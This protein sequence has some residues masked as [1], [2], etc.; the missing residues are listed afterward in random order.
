MLAVFQRRYL[1]TM[2]YALN[3][4]CQQLRSE[5]EYLTGGDVRI[6]CCCS[7]KVWDIRGGL[8]KVQDRIDQYECHNGQNQRWRLMCINVSMRLFEIQSPFCGL[9]AD[10]YGGETRNGVHL[11]VYTKHGGDNQR[12]VLEKAKVEGEYFI[13][14]W[15]SNLV[16][17]VNCASN[18]SS[19]TIIQWTRHGGT[20]QRFRIE[21]IDSA[22]SL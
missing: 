7:G 17:D 3:M 4:A 6:V 16:L 15:H 11:Q 10:V 12:F 19:A 2:E 21:R 9:V 5:F 1:I 13:R 8:G 14:A 20:N 18:E 22:T